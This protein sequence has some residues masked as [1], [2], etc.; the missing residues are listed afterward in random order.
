MKEFFEN[1]E[2]GKKLKKITRKTSQR[3]HGQPVY[4]LTEKCPEYGL[5]KGDHVYLDA[6][7]RDHL[8]IC[9]KNTYARG[10]LNIDG[11]GNITKANKAIK[12]NRKL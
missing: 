1:T 10:V 4:E 5:R 7:H 8:E 3:K 9:D 12:E 6:K 2:F 11:S